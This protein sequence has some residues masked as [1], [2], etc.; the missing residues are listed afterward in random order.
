M[1][2]TEKHLAVLKK[3]FGFGEFRAVQWKIIKSIIEVV[4]HLI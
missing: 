2:P 4:G 1:G 3:Y